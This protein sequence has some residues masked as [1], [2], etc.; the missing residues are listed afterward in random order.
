MPSIF[1]HENACWGV[2][3]SFSNLLHYD[4]NDDFQTRKLGLVIGPVPSSNDSV[5][6][7]VSSN[8]YYGY[9]P[10][11]SVQNNFESCDNIAMDID[12]N[13]I[14]ANQF[15]Q[16]QQE[17]KSFILPPAPNI[18]VVGRKRQISGDLVENNKRMRPQGKHSH[19]SRFKI[20]LF[21]Q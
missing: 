20:S 15:V 1:N 10:H 8:G 12:V 21:Q 19:G 9:Q 17:S 4:L 18:Q 13:N 5:K 2:K 3:K 6:Y 14:P 7:S 11:S 16:N